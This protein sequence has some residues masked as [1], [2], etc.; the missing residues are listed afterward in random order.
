LTD[1]AR[2]IA[3]ILLPKLVARLARVVALMAPDA[4]RVQPR[5]P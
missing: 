2:T 3:A 5:T 1:A 4:S